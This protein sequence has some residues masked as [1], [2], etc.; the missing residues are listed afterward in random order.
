MHPA[1]H[2]WVHGP[3]L[4]VDKDRARSTDLGAAEEALCQVGSG[5]DKW[6]TK[7]NCGLI[8]RNLKVCQGSS[9]KHFNGR[10]CLTNCKIGNKEIWKRR[11]RLYLAYGA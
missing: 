10:L 6:P 9:C 8:S 7:A 5:I 1:G 11:R 2:L 3:P 4:A